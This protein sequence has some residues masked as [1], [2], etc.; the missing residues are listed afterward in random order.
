MKSRILFFSLMLAI[1]TG[2]ALIAGDAE[3]LSL[4][5]MNLKKPASPKKMAVS[6]VGQLKGRVCYSPSVE[7]VRVIKS[8]ERELVQ[9]ANGFSNL[10]KNALAFADAQMWK[11]LSLS[12]EQEKLVAASAN[13]DKERRVQTIEAIQG[14]IAGVYAE[15]EQLNAHRL[16]NLDEIRTIIEMKAAGS[17]FLAPSLKSQLNKLEVLSK[18]ISVLRIDAQSMLIAVIQYWEQQKAAIA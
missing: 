15:F 18:K 3:V 4:A 10:K 13:P 16:R 1:C 5:D 12:P 2:G 17:F 6:W 7:L 14:K 11:S 8:F 9:I